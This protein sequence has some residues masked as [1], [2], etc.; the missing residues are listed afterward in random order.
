M[1]IN[2]NQLKSMT[3]G[4]CPTP[5]PREDPLNLYVSISDQG[6]RGHWP[7]TALETFRFWVDAG[8]VVHRVRGSVPALPAP[9]LLTQ[10]KPQNSPC[11]KLTI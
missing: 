10:P 6:R 11:P 9:G 5:S 8:V 4:V 1:K 3:R 2:Y 7:L